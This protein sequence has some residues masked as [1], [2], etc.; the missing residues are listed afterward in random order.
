[1][2]LAELSVPDLLRLRAAV[3]RVHMK[4]YPLD[5]CDAR[6]CDRIIET[7][8]PQTAERLLQKLVDGKLQD[9]K[10]AR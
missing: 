10:L 3:R 2:R 9:G 1:M 8:M 6:T 7:L 4:H 5:H